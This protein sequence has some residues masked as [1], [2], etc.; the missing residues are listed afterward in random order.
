MLLFFKI[1]FFVYIAGN[2]CLRNFRYLNRISRT[3]EDEAALSDQHDALS[4]AMWKKGTCF[5]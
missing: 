5:N 2:V 1:F 4:D 3:H